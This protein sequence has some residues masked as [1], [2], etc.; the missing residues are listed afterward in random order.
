MRRE[1]STKLYI[2]FLFIILY[3]F[4]EAFFDIAAKN[5]ILPI[6]MVSLF[7]KGALYEQQNTR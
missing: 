1:R 5:F 6:L 4:A 2:L 3:G 7:Q